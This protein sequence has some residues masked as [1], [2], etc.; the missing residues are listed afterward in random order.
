MRKDSID[1][2]A[3]E[4]AYLIYSEKGH[5]IVDYDFSHAPTDYNRG[6]V[7]EPES[8]GKLKQS[9]NEILPNKPQNEKFN[10]LQRRDDEIEEAIENLQQEMKVSRQRGAFQ[11]L[12]NQMRQMNALIKEKERIDADMAVANLGAAQM[13]VYNDTM[14]Q[15]DFSEMSDIGSKI[16]ELEARLMEYREQFEG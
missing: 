2:K 3:I 10:T 14:D 4:A 16:A 7:Q 15:D 11:Q 1:Q 5:Q 9:F 8:N 13:S 6:T 12:Q